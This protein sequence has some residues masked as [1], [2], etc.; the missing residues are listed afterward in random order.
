VG[1]KGTL[2]EGGIHV[3][4][5]ASGYRVGRGESAA[6]VNTTDVFATVAELAGVDLAATL[7]GVVLDSV[8]FAPCLEDPG[9]ELRDSI[10]AEYFSLNGPGQPAPLPACPAVPVCQ[11]DVGYDG[12]GSVALTSCGPPLYGVFGWNL[13]PWQVSGGPPFASAWLRIGALQPAFDATLGTWVVSSAPAFTLPFQLDASGGYASATWTATTSRERH[14]QVVAQDPSQARGFA[15]SSAL[16]M[17]LLSTHMR[18]VRDRRFKLIRQDPCREELYDL[19]L[20]PLEL[21]NLLSAPLCVRELA[22]YQ[23]LSARLD[24]LH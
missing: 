3:P 2:Y 13:V 16:Q 14:Y 18:A 24:A 19:A 12:P 1:A 22:A 15:V 17:D 20:D 11:A 8:S 6:L 5:I 21:T 4:L 10:F 9:L 23:T 7:P